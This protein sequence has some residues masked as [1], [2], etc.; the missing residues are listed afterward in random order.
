[1]GRSF[2]EG[3]SRR[4]GR[5]SGPGRRAAGAS[6]ERQPRS[7]WTPQPKET[8]D[9]AS[10]PYR[11]VYETYRPTQGKENWELYTIKADGSD[12]VN[13]TNTP[14]VHEMYPHVSPDGRW[15]AYISEE[16]GE[17]VDEAS[18]AGFFLS[19]RPELQEARQSLQSSQYLSSGGSGSVG[20]I[21][22]HPAATA[23]ANS[24]N[25]IARMTGSSSR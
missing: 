13:L 9:L 20:S 19:I 4:C 22:E 7:L 10:I 6:S 25:G 1:M 15:I 11:L 5:G 12:P 16:S 21:S 8:L 17:M 23:A 3:K 24:M 2:P 18:H 14:D